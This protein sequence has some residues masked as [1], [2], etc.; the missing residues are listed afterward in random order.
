M[1][2]NLDRDAIANF[3]RA[4]AVNPFIWEAFEGL[5]QLG[6]S[7][8]FDAITISHLV[9]CIIGS[10]P[11]VDEIM[12]PR[13]Q[14]AK[15]SVSKAPASQAPVSTP[16]VFSNPMGGQRPNGTTGGKQPFRLHGSYAGGRESMY[17]VQRLAIL[18]LILL[19]NQMIYSGSA[20]DSSFGE[21]NS[22]AFRA[23]LPNQPEMLTSLVVNGISKTQPSD[24][25]PLPKRF[26]G[27]IVASIEEAILA[28]K[29]SNPRTA[30]PVAP[31]RVRR[32]L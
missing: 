28:N 25:R 23:R 10:F 3:N 30:Q 31:K 22:P 27:E 4:L 14:F 9:F 5:C 18:S 20:M 21:L 11:E 12:P 1:K 19:A 13:G 15:S 16:E 2:G 7:T 17:G 24:I 29:S 8:T 32:A 6:N 26:R